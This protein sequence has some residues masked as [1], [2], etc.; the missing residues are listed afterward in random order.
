[1]IRVPSLLAGF[2]VVGA[3]ALPAGENV[4]TTNGPPAVITALGV[5][6]EIVLAGGSLFAGGSLVDRTVGF[7][8]AAE[9][10]TWIEVGELPASWSITDFLFD[11]LDPA[12]IYA[13]ASS[14]TAFESRIYRSE[15]QGL[16]WREVASFGGLV[17]DLAAPGGRPGVLYA[18]TS[19]CREA[20]CTAEVQKS[21]DF[22]ATWVIRRD[23]LAGPFLSTIAVDP[24]DPNRIYAGGAGVFVSSDAG[25]H[26]SAASARPSCFY[27][28]ALAIRPSDGVVFAGAGSVFGFG[29][30]RT[31]CGGVYRSTDGGKNWSPI[32]LAG[33][34]VTSVAIDAANSITL[35]AGTDLVSLSDVGGV[36][37]SNDGGETWAPFS[38]GL[39]GGG[40]THLVIDSS[41]RAL[42]AAA[43]AGR[44]FDIEL[45]PDVRLPIAPVRSRETRTLPV[46]P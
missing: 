18:A 23:G 8:S 6:S 38:V 17:L 2:L 45:T 14:Y 33:E 35:Y 9:D 1:V 39:P 3:A 26:W 44:V 40:V 41:G 13:A 11:P 16:T 46:R 20:S 5:N 28:L 24:I 4:W 43:T 30:N 25:E 32:G 36:F 37:R 19:S 7:R 42:H 10:S 12:R 21:V 31:S 22:G 29:L 34:Y 15:D 27:V